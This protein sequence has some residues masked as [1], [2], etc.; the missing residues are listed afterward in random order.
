MSEVFD[1]FNPD[2]EYMNAR[3][4]EAW[5]QVTQRAFYYWAR[6]NIFQHTFYEYLPHP[7]D[8]F[9]KSIRVVRIFHVDDL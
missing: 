3:D 2:P 1:G 9:N 6:R 5:N 4:R 7:K 8:P